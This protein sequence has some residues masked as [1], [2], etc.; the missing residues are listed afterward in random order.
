MKSSDFKIAYFL[1]KKVNIE[2]ASKYVSSKDLETVVNKK[3]LDKNI[4][5]FETSELE[6]TLKGIFL[7]IK[8]IHVSKSLPN[9]L[10]IKIVERTPLASLKPANSSTTFLIDGDG[11]VL[12]ELGDNDLNLPLVKYAGKNEVKVGTFVEKDIVTVYLLLI[13]SLNESG[14]K[15]Q[16]VFVDEDKI[17]IIIN[18]NIVTYL[19]VKRDVNQSVNL[20]KEVLNK[21]NNENIMLKRVDLRYDK[22]VVEY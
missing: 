19:S 22:V 4:L 12:G 11:Y 14:I 17:E 1:I 18:G 5:T 2:G 15:F 16:S 21:Y 6:K 10:S 3:A 8:D 9:T 7:A 13:K 20:L